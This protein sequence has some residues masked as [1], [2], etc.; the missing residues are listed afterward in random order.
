MKTFL[1]KKD[2]QDHLVINGLVDGKDLNAIK[3]KVERLKIKLNR[4]H[5][6]EIAIFD[7]DYLSDKSGG[8][9]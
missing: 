6:K 9:Q 3:R 1:I 2:D 7:Y 4:R 8:V 5:W